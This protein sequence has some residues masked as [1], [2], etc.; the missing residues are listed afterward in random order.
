[1]LTTTANVGR[2]R[3][4]H[5]IQ[6]PAVSGHERFERAYRVQMNTLE[7]AAIVL[8]V[9]WVNAGFISDRGA[10]AL[11]AIWLVARIWY[12][13]AY[14]KEPTMRGPAFVLSMV[15]LTLLWLAA[16]FGVVR[17]LLRY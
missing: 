14:L 12:A 5:N 6:A 4:G 1:M 10:A 17:V 15:A 9:M 7:N 16:A 11:G 13:L 2:A 8:P 3:G